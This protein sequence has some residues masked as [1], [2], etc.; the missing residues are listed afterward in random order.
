MAQI[1]HA[2]AADQAKMGVF[3]AGANRSVYCQKTVEKVEELN[4]KDPRSKNAALLR[5]GYDV[6]MYPGRLLRGF[7]LLVNLVQ[8]VA[9]AK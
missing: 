2:L 5:Q 6:A 9:D 7:E 1:A 8:I 3:P 4:G